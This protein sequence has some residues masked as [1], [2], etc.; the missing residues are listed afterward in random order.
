MACAPLNTLSVPR[1]KRRRADE[2]ERNVAR[3]G[4]HLQIINRSL[5]AV[6]ELDTNAVRCN[7]RLDVVK[8]REHLA[9]DAF[10]EFV[11]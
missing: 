6:L 9:V 4:K 8:E 2:F 7:L 11:K 3:R 5:E 1:S 10:L